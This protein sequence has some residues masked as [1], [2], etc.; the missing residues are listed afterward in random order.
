MQI[1]FTADTHFL[2]EGI[3]KLSGRPFDSLEHMTE[4]MINNWNSVVG[5]GDVVY[6]L[7]DFA[8]SWGKR[9][10]FAPIDTILS[11]LNGNKHL[12]CGNHDREEVTRNPRW[13][14][15]SHYR[16]LKVRL[17]GPDKQRIVMSHYAFR[18]WNQMHRGAWMLC[19]HSHGNLLDYPG[20][21]KDVG[22]D[23]CAYTPISLDEIQRYMEDRPIAAFD[24]H[25][26]RIT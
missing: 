9:S 6:H 26:P 7:G 20:K 17:G 15:V 1:F 2:H 12:V 16:E 25:Q 23:C 14:S 22:V 18:V 11:R 5:R 24:H 8:L 13:S 21:W 4:S 3:L 19:G 10:S